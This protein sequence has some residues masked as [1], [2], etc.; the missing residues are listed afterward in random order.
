MGSYRE[1]RNL[2][3]LLICCIP[4]TMY[5]QT[6]S[7]ASELFRIELTDGS[8]LIGTILHQENNRIELLTQSGVRVEINKSQ[9]EDFELYDVEP[10]NIYGMEVTLIATDCFSVQ[11]ADR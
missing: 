2:V 11:Q 3:L 7:T 5:A 6:D 10:T 9:I 1:I 4:F 8:V